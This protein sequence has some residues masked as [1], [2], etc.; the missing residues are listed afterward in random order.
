[1]DEAL[2]RS[3]LPGFHLAGALP[4]VAV[5]VGEGERWLARHDDLGLEVAVEVFLQPEGVGAEGC[6]IERLERL[7]VAAERLGELTHRNVAGLLLAGRTE[8]GRCF[9]MTEWSGEKSLARELRELGPEPMLLPRALS[10]LAQLAA[11]LHVAHG[12]GVSHRDLRPEYVGFGPS[13]PD[14]VVLQLHG[15]GRVGLLEAAGVLAVGEVDLVNPA[16]ASPEH[17]LGDVGGE[18]GAEVGGAR[19]DVYALGVMAFRLCTGRLPL[20]CASLELYRAAHRDNAPRR[21][22]DRRPRYVESLPEAVDELILACL[23]KDPAARPLPME[24]SRALG[25]AARVSARQARDQRREAGPLG[26]WKRIR[27][28]A[29]ET[30]RYVQYVQL[31]SEPLADA[32]A[33]FGPHDEAQ[34]ARLLAAEEAGAR[35]DEVHS[36]VRGREHRLRRAV[37]ALGLDRGR[38]VAT[39]AGDQPGTQELGRQ[40][41]ELLRSVATARAEDAVALVQ[42]TTARTRAREAAEDWARRE[43]NRILELVQAVRDLREASGDPSLH[44]RIDA[45]TDLVNQTGGGSVRTLPG[46]KGSD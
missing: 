15:L 39:G 28:K 9:L 7:L 29:V 6:G 40:I 41:D 10:V 21:P 16:Y 23:A 11:A 5:G 34:Q 35:W 33:A 45:L 30:A 2:G 26:V 20:E 13:K 32:L 1:M 4:G 12:V 17:L 22:Q 44:A 42:A 46:H 27:A 38:L 19:A 36:E 37:L 14:D 43:P 18:V 31:G 25:K 8:D 3:L 24:L